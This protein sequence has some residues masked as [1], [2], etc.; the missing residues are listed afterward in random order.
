MLQST[1]EFEE[2]K[3]G[4]KRK[5]STGD[6][7]EVE[8][9]LQQAELDAANAAKRLRV[10]MGTVGFGKFE[11]VAMAD[12]RVNFPEV[13]QSKAACVLAL[14]IQRDMRRQAAELQEEEDEFKALVEEHAQDR[15]VTETVQRTKSLDEM[16]AWAWGVAGTTCSALEMFK[17]GARDKAVSK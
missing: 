7:I 15:P 5:R 10:E 17:T 11:D 3:Q 6:H 9:A 8:Q 12:S 1:N 4:V 16:R 13:G 14:Q 2:Q